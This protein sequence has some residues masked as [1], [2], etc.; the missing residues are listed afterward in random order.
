MDRKDKEEV[1]QCEEEWSRELEN[2][3]CSKCSDTSNDSR[4]KK[5]LYCHYCRYTKGIR[6]IVRSDGS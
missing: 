6:K 2:K 5:K 4:N 1:G 3:G